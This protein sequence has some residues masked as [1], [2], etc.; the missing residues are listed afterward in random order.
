MYKRQLGEES[1]YPFEKEIH[2]IDEVPK[3]LRLLISFNKN[4]THLKIKSL[5]FIQSVPLQILEKNL[6][7]KKELW[8][9]I[10]EYKNADETS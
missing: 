2:S 4:K 7:D 3:R 5:H 8:L 10:K 9:K 6:N 1:E